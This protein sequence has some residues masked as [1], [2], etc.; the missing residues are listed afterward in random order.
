MSCPEFEF[1]ARTLPGIKLEYSS[2]PHSL[3]LGNKGE[4]KARFRFIRQTHKDTLLCTYSTVKVLYQLT[5]KQPLALI[6]GDGQT[7]VNGTL[8]H[9]GKS[10]FTASAS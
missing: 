10:R 6:C 7:R 9:C 3:L 5:N 1:E 8:N 2:S 4:T